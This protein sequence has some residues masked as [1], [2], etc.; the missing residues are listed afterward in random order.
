MQRRLR[1]RVA[2]EGTLRNPA[3]ETCIPSPPLELERVIFE[4]VCT[5]KRGQETQIHS[6]NNNL[7]SMVLS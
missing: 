2:V 3:L 5:L 4:W 7:Y 1:R 6:G